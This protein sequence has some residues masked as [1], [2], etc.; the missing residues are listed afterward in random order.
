[1]NEHGQDEGKFQE[2]VRLEKQRANSSCWRKVKCQHDAH[3][4]FPVLKPEYTDLGGV[5][6]NFSGQPGHPFLFLNITL[7]C[8]SPEA[9]N[10]TK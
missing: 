4:Y 5:L 1:M 6:S 7:P 9:E 3:Y 8:L 10:Y 2:G